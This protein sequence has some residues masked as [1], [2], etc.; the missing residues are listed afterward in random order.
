MFPFSLSQ[1]LLGNGQAGSPV[2]IGYL[3]RAPL[4]LRETQHVFTALL[5][6]HQN[7][8]DALIS[9]PRY[10]PT[11][12]EEEP[13]PE[14][15]DESAGGSWEDLYERIRRQKPV[16]GAS[17]G[18]VSVRQA[19][20]GCLEL[21]FNGHEFDYEMVKEKDNFAL[22]KNL[23]REV[24]GE[25]VTVTLRIGGKEEHAQTDR[26]RQLQKKALKHPMVTEALEIFG[27]EVVEVR[28]GPEKGK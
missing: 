14:A 12:E 17:L 22:I 11:E 9:L 28:V 8:H 4:A 13:E 21:D 15:G 10:P 5:T 27:G 18:R 3:Y 2:S 25:G 20:S 1:T 23:A 6:V 16:L 7:G 19:E 26:E 24:L